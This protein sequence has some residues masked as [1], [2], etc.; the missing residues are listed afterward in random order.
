[1]DMLEDRL[2][3]GSRRRQSWNWF[4]AAAYTQRV[5]LGA[6][7]QPICRTHSGRTLFLSPCD[8]DVM[9]MGGA[10]GMTAVHTMRGCHL[11]TVLDMATP[12]LWSRYHRR[13]PFTSSEITDTAG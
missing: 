2:L 9:N 4:S 1:M 5:R 11:P 3:K 8:R 6:Y 7:G 10:A 13:L 12:I